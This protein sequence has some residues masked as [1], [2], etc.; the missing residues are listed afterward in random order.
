MEGSARSWSNTCSCTGPPDCL[1]WLVFPPSVLPSSVM[2]QDALM[3]QTI[4]RLC[5]TT[6]ISASMSFLYTPGLGY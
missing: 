3:G 5:D 1:A 6:E 4:H 2:D